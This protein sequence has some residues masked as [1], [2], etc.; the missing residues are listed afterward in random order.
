MS[1]PTPAVRLFSAA[2]GEFV[3]PDWA[4]GADSLASELDTLAREVKVTQVKSRWRVAEGS[5]PRSTMK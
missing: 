5:P 2:S 1:A 4:I 3:A